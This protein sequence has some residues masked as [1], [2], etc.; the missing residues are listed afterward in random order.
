MGQENVDP[1]LAPLL[2]SSNMTGSI[3]RNL[4]HGDT[5]MNSMLTT[6]WYVQVTKEENN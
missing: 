4:N 1:V 2:W 6:Y 5:T 3:H